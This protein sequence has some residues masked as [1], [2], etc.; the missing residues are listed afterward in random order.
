MFRSLYRISGLLSIICQ[1][2]RPTIEL[3]LHFTIESIINVCKC[4]V[5]YEFLIIKILM[6]VFHCLSEYNS[7]PEIT[8]G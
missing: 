3:M 1:L 2:L 4:F 5:P 8:E 6:C 7:D